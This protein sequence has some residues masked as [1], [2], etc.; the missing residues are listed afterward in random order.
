MAGYVG[1]GT[2]VAAYVASTKEAILISDVHHVCFLIKL[3]A[4]KSLASVLLL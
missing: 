1:E 4:A 3:S 2:T